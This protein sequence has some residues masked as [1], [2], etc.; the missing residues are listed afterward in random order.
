M[1]SGSRIAPQH[2]RRASARRR[3]APRK[4]AVREVSSR[5][6]AARELV[7]GERR[8]RTAAVGRALQ[9]RVVVHDDDAVAR[10]VH[11]E[12]EPV[13]AEGQAVIEGEQGVLRPERR[14]AAMRVDLRP[15]GSGTADVQ[16]CYYQSIV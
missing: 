9:G 14:A 15:S 4:A 6:R 2:R 11:V 13:R 3:R 5:R 12:L 1:M 10:E 7:G 8:Q 16:V